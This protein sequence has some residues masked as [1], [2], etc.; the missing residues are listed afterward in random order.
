MQIFYNVHYNDTAHFLNVI[1]K[2]VIFLSY[3]IKIIYFH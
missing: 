3:D 1:L 2:I